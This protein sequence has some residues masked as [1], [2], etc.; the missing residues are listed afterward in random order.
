MEEQTATE[1]VRAPGVLK[2]SGVG[3]P[4][5]KR[6]QEINDL[7]ARRAYELFESRGFT[8]GL[9]LADWLRAESDILHPIPLDV[10]ET[11][12][13]LTVRAE[14]PGFSEKDLEVRVE[15]RRL[16][17]TGKHQEASEQK[18]GK[19]V[20]SERHATQIFRVLDLPTSINPDGV[21]AT[22]SD[23]VLEVTLLKAEV[24]KKIP[25]LAKAASA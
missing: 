3:D 15:P 6:V 9:D 23:G 13:E 11:E 24:G 10:T 22:L 16:F 12:T 1:L 5:F 21:K 2:L 14:V 25:V 20:Y 17:I 8:H 4:F 18:K 19:S 7:I